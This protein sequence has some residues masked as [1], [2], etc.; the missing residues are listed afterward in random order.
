M[1]P[2]DTEPERF[3]ALWTPRCFAPV[4]ARG[5]WVSH[6]RLGDLPRPSPPARMEMRAGGPYAY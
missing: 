1:S 4:S 3:A 5:D 6:A 2:S